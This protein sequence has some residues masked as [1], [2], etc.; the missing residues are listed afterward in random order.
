MKIIVLAGGLSPER[1]VSLISGAGICRTLL[2]K[3]HQAFLLDVFFGL[4]YDS[5]RLEEVFSLPDHGL[6][7]AKGIQTTAPDLKAL[8]TAR[9]DDSSCYLGPNVTELCRMAD[10][11]FIALHGSDGENGKIQATFDLLGIRYT[12]PNSLG[13]ALSMNK[14]VAKQVF[15]MSRVPTPRGTSLTASTKD[16]PLEEL[17]Y[18]LPLVIKPCSGGSSIGVYIVHTEEEY[19]SAIHQSFYVDGQEEVV[20]EPYIKGR[21]YACSI[22]AGKALPLVEIIP[23]DGIFNYANKYQQ[24]GAAELCPPVSLDSKTQKKMRKA[25]EKAFLSL[26][27]DVYA[28]ADFIVDESDGKFYCLEMNGLPGMT[29]A[30][31][32]PKAAK[33]AGLEYGDLCEKI[34]EESIAARYSSPE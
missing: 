8:R 17:G 2:E 5:A 15:K 34:I 10:I 30:S 1:D 16:L 6:S 12:G 7:I 24:G 32:M 28:R 26:R 22:I 23:K 31:L 20:I 29:P 13:C 4:P 21:E 18:Y 3:G 14:L 9:Q 11:T 27:L 33:A 19:R 25:A